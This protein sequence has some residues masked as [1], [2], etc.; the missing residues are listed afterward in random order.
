MLAG[1]GISSPISGITVG[2]ITSGYGNRPRVFNFRAVAMTTH[3]VEGVEVILYPEK[4]HL[5]HLR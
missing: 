5:S 4:R 2:K 1:R 3:I